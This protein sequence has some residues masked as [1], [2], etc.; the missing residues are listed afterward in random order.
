M[1]NCRNPA[2][3]VSYCLSDDN[4]TEATQDVSMEQQ[5]RVWLAFILN[6]AVRKP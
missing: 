4:V 6:Q 3:V 5:A 1:I 2:S